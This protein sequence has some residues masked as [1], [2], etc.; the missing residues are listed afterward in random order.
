MSILADK[1]DLC[2]ALEPH[3]SL[4]LNTISPI[5]SAERMY[6]YVALCRFGYRAQKCSWLFDLVGKQTESFEELLDE[7]LIEMTLKFRDLSGCFSQLSARH[8]LTDR[9]NRLFGEGK[10]T[11][12]TDADGVFRYSF[13]RLR[14][15]CFQE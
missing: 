4:R 13:M 7:N 12:S 10:D 5:T 14:L 2:D 15:P 3:V 8:N 1:Y 11:T 9:E 6:C